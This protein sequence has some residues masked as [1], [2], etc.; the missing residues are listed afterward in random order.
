MST[1]TLRSVKGSGLTNAEIDANFTN[2][3]SD[4]LEAGAITDERAAVATLTNKTLTAPT[5]TTPALG[6][7]SATSVN[8]VAITAPATSATLTLAQ[9]STLATSG[10]FSTTLTATAT[11]NVTLPTTGTL[12]TLAGTETLT[13][14]TLTAPTLT[15]QALNVTT[16]NYPAI[17]P[18]LDLDF[19][20]SQTV[21]PRITFTRAS[22]A[23]RTNARGLI[24]A[25]A[26]GV[27]RIDFDAVTGACKG[28]LIEEQRTNLLTYSEQFD[29]AVWAKTRATVTA[30]AAT[31]PDGT[32]TADKLVEDTTASATH[33]I[34][35]VT[36]AVTF[37]A[38]THCGS[39]YVKAGERSR[40]QAILVDSVGIVSGASTIFDLTAGT[41]VSGSQG[42][43]SPV[44]SGWYRI[45]IY[46]TPAAG[47]TPSGGGLRIHLDNGTTQTYTGDGTSG[48][49]IWGAQLE[50]GAFP[51]SY[52]PTVAS[53]VTRVADVASMTGANFSSWYR[54]DEGSFV[55]D[56]QGSSTTGTVV[57]AND[58]TTNERVHI[59]LGV[60]SGGNVNFLVGDGAVTQAQ[61]VHPI[62]VTSVTKIAARYKV[63]DFSSSANGLTSLTDTSGTI[64]TPDRL[65][66][67]ALGSGL[68]QPNGYIRA[69]SYYPKALT[70][71]ELQALSTQ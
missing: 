50:A 37:T 8:K 65:T 22:T 38:V 33:Y 48:L 3:N 49:F 67:G 35:L 24:E 43:I 5:L 32:M 62:T 42:A 30:N 23:T 63:N 20:N 61:T 70:S 47:L 14:K 57:S 7:A 60:G 51:T 39:A 1:I 58:G 36:N 6:V 44:G 66:I 40:L 4:K 54:Q 56:F 34:G 9:G 11:T 15:T 27:P 71:A 25:V 69:I 53:Q 46:G 52:I 18:S 29:N 31:A 12:A 13:N 21:D 64:P 45:S 10:A 41:V 59:S 2:L 28:L 17:R 26:S 19:A 55:A 68:S 16:N